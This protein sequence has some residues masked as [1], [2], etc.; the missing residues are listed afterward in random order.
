MKVLTIN[1]EKFNLP[2]SWNEL[3]PDQLLRVAE[4]SGQQRSEADFKMKLLLQVT[5]LRMVE[6]DPVLLDGEEH[7]YLRTPGRNVYL[8]SVAQLNEVIEYLSFLFQ[9]DEI[10]VKGSK[11]KKTECVLS[12]RLTRNLIGTVKVGKKFWHG[13]ADGLSNLKTG[14]FIRAEMCLHR[15]FETQKVEYLHMLFCTLWRPRPLF[16]LV[17]AGAVEHN[18]TDI[19]AAFDDGLVE[20]RAL[21]VK[22][23][24]ANV[25][26]A[27][28]LYY[29]G[30]RK[31]MGLKFKYASDSK[32]DTPDKDIF[33]NFMRLVNALANSDVTKHEAVRQAYLMETM[34]TM[35]E[36]ARQ[37]ELQMQEIEKLK[38]RR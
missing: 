20:K 5:G 35:D 25:L 2:G 14:E 12:S 32:G 38:K 23:V 30:S 27:V 7:F 18:S 22:G 36:M 15:Y 17:V 21:E 37:R 4:L 6:R 3:T 24:S 31:M 11:E 19:R 9:Y 10:E 13:P 8:M 1:L 34:I 26:A 33:M 28:L 29:T 16:H